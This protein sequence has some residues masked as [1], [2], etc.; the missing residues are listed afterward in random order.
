MGMYDEVIVTCPHCGKISEK[1]T[2]QFDCCLQVINLDE[3]VEAHIANGLRGK[4]VCEHCNQIFYLGCKMP[5]KI[6][7]EKRIEERE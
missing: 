7:L 6:L 1:Q 2:K 3:P 5:D 4:Y